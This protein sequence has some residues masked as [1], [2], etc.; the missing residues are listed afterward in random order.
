MLIAKNLLSIGDAI[1][2]NPDN[3]IPKN[4]DLSLNQVIITPT[5][6]FSADATNFNMTVDKK[7][8]ADVIN[9]ISP[10]NDASSP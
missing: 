1:R 9:P 6:F 10:N 5:S 7:P 3:T 4:N 2:Y 8:K